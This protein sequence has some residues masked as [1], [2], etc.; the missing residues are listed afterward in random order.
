M[1]NRGRP[2]I[3]CVDDEPNV[4][5]GLALHL[6]RRFDVATA[7]S[8]QAALKL[9]QEGAS[10]CVVMSDMRMPGMD[11]AELLSRVRKVAPDTVRI[12]LTGQAEMKSAIAAINEGQIFRFLTKPCPPVELLAAFDAALEQHRLLT[13]ERVLLEQTLHGSIKTLVD[14]LS[15]TSPLSFGRANRLKTR[16]SEL[17]TKLE[18]Q[19]IWQLEVAALLSE[20]GSITLPQDVLERVHTGASLSEAEQKMLARVPEVTE[21]LLQNIPR[22]E[23]VRAI[24]ARATKPGRHNGPLV[25]DPS[26]RS[27]ELAARILRVS[28]DFDALEAQGHAPAL[29][30]DTMRGRVDRYDTSVLATF[31][32]LY[33]TSTVGVEQIRELPLSALKPGM[34]FTEDLRFTNGA[35]LCARGY[36]VNQSFLERARNFRAG[37]VKEPVR[38]IVRAEPPKSV[39]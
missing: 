17:A 18:L 31:A 9:V 29:C 28:I 37:S 35:L 21:Q 30:I 26:L 4:L 38:V 3:L 20:L 7:D 32:A 13:A 33:G 34:I 2:R 12:L 39:R 16:A 6:R 24:I 5:E 27:N 23:P 14:V 19:D 11:G 8:G 10:F 15:L 1:D 22:L 25:D 36:E